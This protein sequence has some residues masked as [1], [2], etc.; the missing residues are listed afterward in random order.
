[1]TNLLPP[2]IGSELDRIEETLWDG[3][4]KL[5][6]ATEAYHSTTC[7]PNAGDYAK[8]AVTRLYLARLA[9][10]GELVSYYV[11]VEDAARQLGEDIRLLIS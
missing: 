11:R 2:T 4:G 7:N 9:E 10:V 5:R 1:M 3:I 8:L 6:A